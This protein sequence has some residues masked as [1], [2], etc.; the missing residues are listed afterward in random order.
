M[1]EDKDDNTPVPAGSSDGGGDG[2]TPKA[3]QRKPGAGNDDRS[4]PSLA[5]LIGAPIAALIDAEAQSAVSTANFINQWGFN[6]GSAGHGD[7]DDMGSLRMASFR[8]TQ[9]NG[10]EQET[11]DVSIPVLSL[12]PIPALQIRDAQLDYTVRI[13]Q[14]E[15]LS[16]DAGAARATKRSPDGEPFVTLR[17]AFARDRAPGD[18][19]STDMLLKMKVRMEQADMPDGLAKLLA[20]S[21]ESVQQLKQAPDTAADQDPTPSDDAAATE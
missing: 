19:R 15:T 4:M 14:T 2:N 7:L 10:D 6:G 16:A 8:R 17:G 12:V 5:Q 18:R 13:I 1:A 3:A 20:L 21:S 11:I 9:Q